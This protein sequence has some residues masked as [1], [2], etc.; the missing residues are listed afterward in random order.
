MCKINTH[1]IGSFT[2]LSLFL[3]YKLYTKGFGSFVH[4]ILD[5]MR[6]DTERKLSEWNFLLIPPY[7]AIDNIF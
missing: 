7:K 3:L 4:G 2:K 5:V 1:L 6:N